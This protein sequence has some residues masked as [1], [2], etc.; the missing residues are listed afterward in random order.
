MKISD[1]RIDGQVMTKTGRIGRVAGACDN[2][3]V[4]V[5]FGSEK[6]PQNLSVCDIEPIARELH[7]GNKVRGIGKSL[8][9]VDFQGK[10]GKVE[11]IGYRTSCGTIC[12]QVKWE[13]GAKCNLA[14]PGSIELVS[15]ACESY[16]KEHRAELDQ[17]RLKAFWE[18]RAL[19]ND[20]IEKLQGKLHRAG[21]MIESQ[22]EEVGH[23]A[24]ER[25]QWK[26]T[27]QNNIR[28]A[29]YWREE[30]DKLQTEALADEKQDFWKNLAIKNGDMLA[31]LLEEEKPIHP[32]IHIEDFRKK[33]L[34][35]VGKFYVTCNVDASGFLAA[36]KKTKRSL[37]SREARRVVEY[38][39]A[40]DCPIDL[41]TICM[42]MDAEIDDLLDSLAEAREAGIIELVDGKYQMKEE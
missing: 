21:A 15:D 8:F 39:T 3:R 16:Q 26:A 27:A 35:E 29:T 37:L 14:P 32:A 25:D 36:I 30:L 23:L 11:A 40:R 18:G 2:G 12:T 34:S 9:G 4:Y 19:S 41:H 33:P 20:K 10:I 17:T 5:L 42:D 1:I 38:I 28:N 22:M 31:E 13:D 24:E 7:V 6:F